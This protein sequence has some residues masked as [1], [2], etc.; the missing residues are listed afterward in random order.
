MCLRFML[1]IVRERSYQ[2]LVDVGCGSGVLALAGLKLG[3]E[4]AVALDIDHKALLISRANAEL[5]GLVKPLM[6]VRGSAEAVAGHFDLVV[7]NLSVSVLIEKIPALSRLGETLVLSGFQDIDK[8]L[9]EKELNRQGLKAKSWLSEDLTFFG[10]SPTG[11]FTW[12]VVLAV[13]KA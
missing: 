8:L 4:R 9:L 13:R 1:Q 3:V 2:N 7:A 5:N 12:M 11:S 6:L 10:E